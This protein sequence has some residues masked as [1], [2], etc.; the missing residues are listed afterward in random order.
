M[1][2][3]TSSNQSACTYPARN[4]LTRCSTRTCLHNELD[5][6]QLA[7]K[8][9]K[10]VVKSFISSS[11]PPD[12]EKERRH[13]LWKVIRYIS[14][15]LPINLALKHRPA[16]QDPRPQT[17]AKAKLTTLATL[18]LRPLSSAFSTGSLGSTGCW[19]R[20]RPLPQPGR[21]PRQ[22]WAAAAEARCFQCW[23]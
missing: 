9:I 19:Q 18:P 22:A 20:R 2:D 10:Q 4:I 6:K 23:R 1:C 12:T 11:V 8:V 16:L 17:S 14:S 15:E 13:E 3:I 7:F 21:E 5:Q